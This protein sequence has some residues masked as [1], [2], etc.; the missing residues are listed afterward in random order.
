LNLEELAEELYET[1]GEDYCTIEVEQDTII[2]F[3]DLPSTENYTSFVNTIERFLLK[4]KYHIED[5]EIDGDY[6]GQIEIIYE[7]E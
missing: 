5:F 6:E 4:S 2:V 7:G 1:I 3:L